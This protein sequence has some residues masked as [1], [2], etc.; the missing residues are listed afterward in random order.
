MLEGAATRRVVRSATPTVAAMVTMVVLLVVPAAVA[1]AGSN[2]DDRPVSAAPA[3]LV[4]AHRGA[5][6]AAPEH[7]GPAY[8]RAVWAGA[9][10]VECDLQ[11][12][13][14]EQL[15]CIHDATVDRTTGGSVTGPVD[16]YTLEELRAMD[17]G[18]WFGPEFEGARVVT[19][20]EQISC[21]RA[22]DPTIRY[23]IETKTQPDQGDTME[24][25]LV[26]LLDR[27]DVTPEF[28]GPVRSSPIIIQSFDL[29]SLATIRRLAPELPTAYLFS[30]PTAEVDAGQLPDVDVLAPNAALITARPDLIGTAHAS[31]MEVHTWTVDDP[32]QMAALVDAG[33]DGLFTNTPATARTVVDQAGRGSGREPIEVGD[34]PPTGPSEIESCP[35]GMGAGLQP[36]NLA[37]PPI[38]EPGDPNTVGTADTGAP[39]E[40]ESTP[41]WPVVVGVVI[42]V[43]VG[44]VVAVRRLQ[45]SRKG[46][47]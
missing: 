36:S 34:P 41:V 3:V 39:A 40:S 20:E 1:G 12:T 23:Y 28:P 42:L 44:V 27:L 19:L 32:V 6:A 10:V 11:L 21:Y 5:S 22:V 18:S 25:A 31:G 17:F 38:D 2:S 9:D 7:T 43:A 37:A 14:D 35:A 30:V 16:S 33:V 45:R 13:A 24:T 8:D 46:S 47:S 26:E 4:V 15:V 29:D